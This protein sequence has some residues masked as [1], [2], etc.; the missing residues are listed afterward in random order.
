MHL[1]TPV[2]YDKFVEHVAKH[3]K[4]DKRELLEVDAPSSCDVTI[5]Q[6]CLQP[7]HVLSKGR[8]GLVPPILRLSAAVAAFWVPDAF[9]AYM[10]S[11]KCCLCATTNPTKIPQPKQ[12]SIPVANKT[13][14]GF[15]MLLLLLGCESTCGSE[16]I[17]IH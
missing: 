2:G 1:V 11:R 13:I 6:H 15:G 7:S 10:Y 4:G 16:M 12:V 8:I 3:L 17:T 5:N 9:R 14:T